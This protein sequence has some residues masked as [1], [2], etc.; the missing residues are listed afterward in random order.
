MAYNKTAFKKLN[1]FAFWT[2]TSVLNVL[3]I[4]IQIYI[5]YKN[6]KD[7]LALSVEETTIAPNAFLFASL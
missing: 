6:G 3:L 1:Y 7:R 2:N 4:K 5:I